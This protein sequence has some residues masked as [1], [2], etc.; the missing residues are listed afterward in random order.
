MISEKEFVNHYTY[1]WNKIFP[2]S[3]RLVRKLN[4]QK[5]HFTDPYISNND[6]DSRAIINETSFRLFEKSVNEKKT[7]NQF[8]ETEVKQIAKKATIYIAELSRNSKY[9][10]Y[11]LNN[12]E[13]NEAVRIAKRTLDYIGNNIQVSPKFPGCSIINSCYG[14][15]KSNNCIYEIKAGDRDF[16]VNDIR[17]LLVYSLL[18]YASNEKFENIGLINPRRGCAVK[19]SL[20]EAIEMASGRG[21][22]EV[23][24]EIL[25]FIDTS[26][27]F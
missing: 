27:T 3:S 8:S 18:N 24:N 23:F 6:P 12:S 4:L 26:E 22:S 13:L 2:F 17:Q 1:Y 7:P 15:M 10:I 5:E 19:I 9:S 16:R 14:D 20:K 11:Y 25:E 21:V